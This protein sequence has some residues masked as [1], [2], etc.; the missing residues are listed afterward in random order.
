MAEATPKPTG[1][2]PPTIGKVIGSE[3]SLLDSIAPIPAEAKLLLSPPGVLVMVTRTL[4]AI[5]NPRKAET[6][7]TDIPGLQDIIRIPPLESDQLKADRIKRFRSQRSALPKS[8]RWI[9]KVVNALDDAQDL[10]YTALVLAKPLLKR[11]PSRVIPYLGWVLLGNDVLNLLTA[12]LGVSLNGGRVKSRQAR[13]IASMTRSFTR[14]ARAAKSFLDKTPLMPFIIQ[15]G[16][17]LYTV[18]DWAGKKLQ[19]NNVFGDPTKPVRTGYGL[20][21]GGIM[22]AMTD[23]VWGLVKVAQG[24]QLVF[25]GPPPADPIQKAARYILTGGGINEA[26]DLLSP[27][28]HLL[29]MAA[30]AVAHQIL[31]DAIT[32]DKFQLRAPE[33]QRIIPPTSTTWSASSRAALIS[34]GINPDTPAPALTINGLPF[35]TLQDLYNARTSQEHAWQLHMREIYGKTGEGAMASVLRGTPD[36]DAI[37]QYLVDDED[38]QLQPS[39]VEAAALRMIEWNRFPIT[40]PSPERIEQLQL[41]GKHEEAARILNPEGK[42]S[43]C[44]ELAAAA[45]ASEGRESPTMQQIELALQLTFGGW[46]ARG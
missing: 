16:Q 44:L 13:A 45:A 33:A 31:A 17:A 41:Q 20:Q 36:H 4:S 3:P 28:D 6:Y 39:G 14:R 21:L 26:K 9:P 29:L 18:T 7:T 42:L 8:M 30:D 43:R 5:Y 35:R 27:E 11:A 46:K 24:D 23:T 40:W 19:E 32:P 37:T 10:L 25:R 15:G 34:A 38:L 22:G 12:V 2:A 1:Q